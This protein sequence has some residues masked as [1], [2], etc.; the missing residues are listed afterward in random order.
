MAKMLILTVAS[1][2]CVQVQSAC[3]NADRF[4]DSNSFT[5]KQAD[6]YMSVD[7]WLDWELFEGSIPLTQGGMFWKEIS[8]DDRVQYQSTNSQKTYEVMR[9]RQAYSMAN[10]DN[11]YVDLVGSENQQ[12]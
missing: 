3:N 12:R 10:P 5:Q 7:T 6:A 2:L 9:V 1:L 4:C 11:N 8:D